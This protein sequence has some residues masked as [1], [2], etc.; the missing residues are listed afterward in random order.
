MATHRDLSLAGKSWM[1]QRAA[2]R[3]AATVPLSEMV[4]YSPPSLDAGPRDL[5]H[6]VQSLPGSAENEGKENVSK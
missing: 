6:A 3:V 1:T 5:Q 2:P 4:R